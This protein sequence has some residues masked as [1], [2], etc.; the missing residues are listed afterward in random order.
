MYNASQTLFVLFSSSC[1]LLFTCCFDRISFLYCFA[2]K[3]T[4]Y[5]MFWFDNV[6]FFSLHLSILMSFPNDQKKWNMKW[7]RSGKRTFWNNICN[8]FRSVSCSLHNGFL[9]F[10]PILTRSAS[11]STNFVLHDMPLNAA[12]V[13]KANWTK[14]FQWAMNRLSFYSEILFRF[15]YFPIWFSPPLSNSAEWQSGLNFDVCIA[16][17]DMSK[18]NS[19]NDFV[20]MSRK[21]QMSERSNNKAILFGIQVHSLH[22]WRLE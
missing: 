20:W 10:I 8:Q 21:C 5:W 13:F 18:M 12:H 17:I 4:S 16:K 11:N 2:I 1:F 19:V 14:C 22:W 7:I 15:A 6:D 9:E 3:A